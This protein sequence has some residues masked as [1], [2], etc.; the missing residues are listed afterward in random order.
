MAPPSR[1]VSCQFCRQRKLRCNRQCPCSNCLS[2][3]IACPSLRTTTNDH[4][5]IADSSNNAILGR[6]DKIE[7]HLASLASSSAARGPSIGEVPV[8]VLK[9]DLNTESHR[10]LPPALQNLT[11]DAFSINRSLFKNNGATPIHNVLVRKCPTAMQSLDAQ[12]KDHLTRVWFPTDEEAQ[13]LVNRYIVELNYMSYIVHGPSLR[14]LVTEA[15]DCGLQISAGPVVLLLAIFAFASRT[16]T[17]D[18]ADLAGLFSCHAQ[19]QGQAESW[20]ST[21]FDILEQCRRNSEVSLELVQGLSILNTAI[22]YFDGLTPQGSV[23]LAQTIAMC[24][25]LGLHRIDHP[26]DKAS[27]QDN[28]D[29]HGVRAEVGRRAWWRLVTLDWM[30][31]ASPGL[32]GGTYSINPLH[33]AVRKPLNIED[34]DLTHT[35]HL[36]SPPPGEP[37]CM[38]FFLERIRLAEKMRMVIDKNP[39][40]AIESYEQVLELD[41]AIASI[42]QDTSRSLLLKDGS[43]PSHPRSYDLGNI[44]VQCH[45]L[46]SL[47]NGQRCRLHLPYLIRSAAEASYGHSR[48][49]AVDSARCIIDAEVRLQACNHRAS[50]KP[51]ML[52]SVLFSYF[53]AVAAL[54]LNLCLATQPEIKVKQQEFAQAWQVLEKARGKVSMIEEGMQI[55]EVT[56]RRHD[57]WP[58]MEAGLHQTPVETQQRHIEI[59][60]HSAMASPTP[61][62]QQDH[63]PFPLEQDG[64]I[65]QSDG[66]DWDILQWVMDMPFL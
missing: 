36:S 51:F 3:G 9:A 10:Q 44:T 58:L 8:V 22:F 30:L 34:E 6:L 42:L 41:S 18:D 48:R 26:S 53:S 65:R 29:L 21:A 12:S 35:S 64:H 50:S 43:V 57:V 60:G 52:G 20:T 27:S 40:T 4:P 45:L 66:M 63:V 46:R 24:R 47:L 31:A 33:M 7:A 25:Q 56:M 19:A 5:Q 15:Y 61:T 37:T 59:Y 49:I 17:H 11:A 62:I 38:F 2:R 16:W 23:T 32:E 28:A 55:L 54:A 39:L 13:V 14:K 1:A